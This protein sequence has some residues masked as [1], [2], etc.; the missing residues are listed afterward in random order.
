MRIFF[1]FFFLI[2]FLSC[3]NKISEN[4]AP[5]KSP[6]V[7]K[8]KGT[9]KGYSNKP[10]YFYAF[11]GFQ[12]FP[13]DSG[14]SSA[15]GEIEL[16]LTSKMHP[17]LYR[18]V[19]SNSAQNN[20]EQNERYIDFIFN[21]EDISFVTHLNF[22]TDSLKI[23]SSKENKGFYDFLRQEEMHNLKMTVLSQFL[24]YY[25]DKDNFYNRVNR[26][27]K[28]KRNRFS[29]YTENLIKKNEKLLFS[30]I[31][32][33]HQ[34]PRVK[35][36][37]PENEVNNYIRENFFCNT[38]FNDT[39]LLRTPYLTEKALNYISLFKN[40]ALMEEEQE[41]LYIAAIDT[42][43]TKAS[44]NEEVFYILAEYMVNGFESLQMYGASEYITTQY[45]LGGPCDRDDIP[46][47][48]LLKA[49]G[50]QKLAI[51]MP[52][53]DFNFTTINGK[54]L[55]L[56][57]VGADYTLL[58]FWASSCPHC[59]D[60]LPKLN[61]ISDELRESKPG[62]FEVV[63]IAIEKEKEPWET[64]IRTENLNFIHSSEI[65]GWETEPARLF[66]INATPMLFLLDKEKNIV[67]KP[68]RLRV[69][70]RFLQ[71]QLF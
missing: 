13:V 5:L 46:E 30:K 55:T 20:R 69:L 40:P 66:N 60:M 68:N 7:Y 3:S 41:E 4:P 2:F 16:N 36:E 63:A 43:M 50:I 38:D 57:E 21:K 67:L 11:Y 52:A 45:I 56:Y 31:I 29:N 12:S 58:I 44:V 32:K 9:I 54:S 1:P 22:L 23:L 47:N 18:L 33:I 49:T 62:F 8:L 51:G 14:F 19:I 71:K 39:F 37:L 35:E 65:A 10:F 24:F 59:T 61:A 34:T 6:S 64:F 48:L 70:E 17:G 53:P 26:Q 15:E 27:V 25:P 42:I 28:R